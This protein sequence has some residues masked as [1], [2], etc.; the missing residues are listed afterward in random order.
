MLYAPMSRATILALASLS[1]VVVA[2]SG[3]AGPTEPAESSSSAIVRTAPTADGGAPD[4][5]GPLPDICEICTDKIRACA[6]WV[7]EDGQCQVQICPPRREPVDCEGTLPEFCVR[8]SDGV[9]ACAHWTFVDGECKVEI[10]PP[11]LTLPE[12]SVGSR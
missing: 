10:C 2:C 11:R 4:C 8:C 9:D 12:T 7:V 6:H 1:T 3:D 5:D